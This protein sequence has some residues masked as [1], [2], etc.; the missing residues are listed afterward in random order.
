MRAACVGPALVVLI[1]HALCG[2]PDTGKC[3]VSGVDERGPEWERL[4]P[5]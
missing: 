3:W 4:L 1:A 2:W 5:P